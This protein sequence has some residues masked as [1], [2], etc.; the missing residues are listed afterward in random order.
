MK[1]KQEEKALAEKI[2]KKQEKRSGK[3]SSKMPNSRANTVGS[4]ECPNSPAK[5]TLT[6][7]S[8]ENVNHV[9]ELMS[10]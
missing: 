4:E 2:R 10:P 9:N 3:T 6:I 7:D 8:L 5:L 1:A